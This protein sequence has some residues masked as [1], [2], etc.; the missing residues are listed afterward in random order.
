M[1]IKQGGR[2][3]NRAPI[4]LR[5]HLWRTTIAPGGSKPTTNLDRQLGLTSHALQCH[6]GCC[7]QF[8]AAVTIF[9]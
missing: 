6:D 2:L 5:V 8:I 1:P 9:L 7:V 3:A 4:W